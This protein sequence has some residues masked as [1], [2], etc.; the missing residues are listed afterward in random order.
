MGKLGIKATAVATGVNSIATAYRIAMSFTA[1]LRRTLTGA[2]IFKEGKGVCIGPVR[3]LRIAIIGVV[4]GVICGTHVDDCT[5]VPMAGNVC[6]IGLAGI[7]GAGI[8]GM[9]MCWSVFDVR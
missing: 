9:G 2:R 3:S 1:N 4:N 5:Q 8:V 6:V 7:K